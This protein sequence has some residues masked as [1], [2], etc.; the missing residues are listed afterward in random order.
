MEWVN[1]T[2]DVCFLSLPIPSHS[3]L[4]S[5]SPAVLSGSELSVVSWRLIRHIRQATPIASRRSSSKNRLRRTL[6]IKRGK[7]SSGC[8]NCTRRTACSEKSLKKKRRKFEASEK[9]RF[10]FPVPFRF[11]PSPPYGLLLGLQLTNHDA[12]ADVPC[13]PSLCPK[14]WP[15][16]DLASRSFSFSFFF[17]CFFIDSAIS[18]SKAMKSPSSSGSRSAWSHHRLA[19]RHTQGIL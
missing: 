14:W 12:D 10:L 1:S 11:S 19:S 16:W 13:C 3:A 4:H 2:F 15:A 9:Q 17:S 7:I 5:A 6:R 8:S 18:C